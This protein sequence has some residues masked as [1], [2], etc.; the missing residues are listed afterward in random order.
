MKTV[1]LSDQTVGTTEQDVEI[2]DT[3]IVDLHDENG[4]HIQVE[5]IVEE[6][7]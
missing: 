2:G 6:I 4:M 1:I 7:L 3:V 5:G